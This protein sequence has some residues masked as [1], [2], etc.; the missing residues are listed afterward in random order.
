MEK[1]SCETALFSH[2]S[3]LLA[4]GAGEVLKL[5]GIQLESTSYSMGRAGR[6]SSVFYCPRS[7]WLPLTAAPLPPGPGPV[8]VFLPQPGARP[9]LV[10]VLEVV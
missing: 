1:G 10:T 9:E 6:A 3:L 8:L 4:C 5:A 2:L 7:V